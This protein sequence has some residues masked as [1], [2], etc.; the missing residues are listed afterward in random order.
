[1]RQIKL[2]ICQ[3]LGARKYTASHHRLSC[4][5]YQVLTICSILH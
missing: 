5:I 3:L 4:G 1:M 2:A